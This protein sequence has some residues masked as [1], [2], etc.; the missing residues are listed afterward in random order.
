MRPSPPASAFICPK[1]LTT[2]QKNLQ[3]PRPEQPEG[4]GLGMLG[5]G[6]VL[7]VASGIPGPRGHPGPRSWGGPAPGWLPRETGL[8]NCSWEAGPVQGHPQTPGRLTWPQNRKGR[9]KVRPRHIQDWNPSVE[10][11]EGAKGPCEVAQ[12]CLSHHS[13]ISQVQTHMR[14]GRGT[15]HTSSRWVRAHQENNLGNMPNTCHQA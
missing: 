3:H 4:L 13:E 1:T 14:G 10:R 11:R 7:A 5:Q 12:P 8:G 9:R 2:P 6:T 15:A